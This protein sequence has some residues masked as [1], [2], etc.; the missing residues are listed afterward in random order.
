MGLEHKRDTVERRS[1]GEEREKARIPGGLWRQH[2]E[3]HKILFYRARKKDR[4]KR[5]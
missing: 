3:N 2:K 4:V 5:I 1:K